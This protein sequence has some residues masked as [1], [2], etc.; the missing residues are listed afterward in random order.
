LRLLLAEYH[1]GKHEDVRV[2]ILP[3][4]GMHARFGAGFFQELLS[5]PFLFHRH[6][7]KQKALVGAVL[8]Q[9]TVLA[10]LDLSNVQHAPK[11]RQHGDFI[12]EL[13]QLRSGYRLESGIAQ[14]GQRGR[15]S[16]GHVEGFF[17]GGIANAPPQFSRL[18]QG[19]ER[20]ALLIQHLACARGW[21]I[22]LFLMHR[23]LCRLA[24]QREQFAFLVDVQGEL[25]LRCLSA[26][27]FQ[28]N[29]CTVSDHPR[30]V[31]CSVA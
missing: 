15:I 8:H 16:H 9:Q 31:A 5:I 26:L 13:H 6:L 27:S 14:G 18:A 24:S 10:N 1:R 25:R 3:A 12:L 4:T 30:V 20:T 21:F 17:R 22:R 23:V 7:R 28:E 2:L 19:H 29:I 11:R